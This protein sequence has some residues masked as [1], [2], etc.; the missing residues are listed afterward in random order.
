MLAF[1]FLVI[2]I[3]S[4]T[5]T[6]G[7]CFTV[8]I[9]PDSQHEED[10]YFLISLNENPLVNL[11]PSNNQTNVTILN[12]DCE[13]LSSPFGGQ[14]IMN[15][16]AAGS[17]ATYICDPDSELIGNVTRV[18][19]ID[20]TWSGEEPLCQGKLLLHTRHQYLM[21]HIILLAIYFL[22]YKEKNASCTKQSLCPF[23]VN[24]LSKQ[25][26]E[27]IDTSLTFRIYPLPPSL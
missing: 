21:L 11:S 2:T 26:L 9:S 24:G 7:V 6:E 20:G 10:E 4:D 5:P 22:T 23:L 3:T 16:T 8:P 14:V 27:K 18:C 19:Q 13:T 12:D 1:M 17:I 25:F 15:G